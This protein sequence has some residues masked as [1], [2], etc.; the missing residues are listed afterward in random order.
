MT[1]VIE[2]L[3]EMIDEFSYLGFPLEPA[4]VKQIA[5]DYAKENNIL[6]FSQDLG[7]TG[8]SWFNYLLKH[9]PKL[10][11]GATNISIM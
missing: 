11:L 4:E 7:T 8:H 9:F 10:H 3:V 5:F 2:Q 6:G 1:L